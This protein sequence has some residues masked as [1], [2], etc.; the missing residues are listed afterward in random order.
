MTPSSA[1]DD[2]HHSGGEPHHVTLRGRD[3]TRGHHPT[4]APTPANCPSPSGTSGSAIRPS[5]TQFSTACER[6][7]FHQ[8]LPLG[9]ALVSCRCPHSRS[10]GSAAMRRRVLGGEAAVSRAPKPSAMRSGLALSSWTAICV[11]V[12]Q[13]P[14]TNTSICRSKPAV[15]SSSSSSWSPSAATT[16]AW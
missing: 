14:R 1:G 16:K 4:R 8:G 11:L 12:D 6:P 3:S 10:G 15:F 13:N 2:G 9:R 7:V 5:P